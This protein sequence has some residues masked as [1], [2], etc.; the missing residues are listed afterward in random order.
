METWALR[1]L[2]VL[3]TLLALGVLVLVREGEPLARSVAK[4]ALAATLLHAAWRGWRRPARSH[5]RARQRVVRLLG[6]L[7]SPD[8]QLDWQESTP[9]VPLATALLD[10]WKRAT[11]PAVLATTFTP[12]ERASLQRFSDALE[13]ARV[14]PDADALTLRLDPSW[15][16][17]QVAA[18]EALA[19]LV[20]H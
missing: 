11:P 2:S 6:V 16:R 10:D 19:A 1:A 17:V 12:E 15:S 14:P 8:R 3:A 9:Q 13:A 5:A 7:A 18:R 20:T 4:A